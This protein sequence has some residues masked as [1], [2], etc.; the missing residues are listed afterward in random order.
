VAVPRRFGEFARA[1]R[2]LARVPSDV[3]RAAAV[4]IERVWRATQR[5]GL[6]PYGGAYAPLTAGSLERGRRP[7]PLRKYARTASVRAMAG[8]GIALR[9]S[10]PQA[11]FHQTGTRPMARRIVVPDRGLPRSWQRT[12]AAQFRRT[13]KRRLA[14]AA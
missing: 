8:A 1:L 6:T 5:A 12:I 11:G 13:I 3:A 14:G 9:Q 10:H 2:A 4:E 7:P